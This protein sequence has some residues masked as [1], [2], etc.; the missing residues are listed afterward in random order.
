MEDIEESRSSNIK[1]SL[2]QKPLRM[3]VKAV[4]QITGVGTVAVG[5]VE[6][7]ILKP[8][9]LLR[10]GPGNLTAECNSIEMGY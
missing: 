5:I 6:S 1:Q 7:G 10:L 4:Y 3:P 2:R 9:Q 8:G